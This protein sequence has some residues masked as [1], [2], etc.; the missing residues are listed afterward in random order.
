[1]TP[2]VWIRLLLIAIIVAVVL[3]VV[4]LHV[5][6]GQLVQE[7][8]GDTSRGGRL[9]EAWCAECHAIGLQAVPRRKAGPDFPAIANRPSTT[10][11]SLNVFLRSEHK[12]MPNF[13][14]ERRNADDILAYIL[15]YIL[16]LKR[17]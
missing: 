16:S 6:T 14:I 3:V 4:R 12:T 8:A 15:A 2:S 7:S 9:A 11:L 13:I 5:A 1:M 17:N 10:A